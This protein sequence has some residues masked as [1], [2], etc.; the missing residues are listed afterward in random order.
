MYTAKQ[1]ILAILLLN[2][3][4]LS[5][6]SPENSSSDGTESPSDYSLEATQDS[7][8]KVTIRVLEKEAILVSF[9]LPGGEQIADTLDEI[10]LCKESAGRD[11]SSLQSRMN[12]LLSWSPNNKF[13]AVTAGHTDGFWIFDINQIQS[14]A[15]NQI[16]K[17]VIAVEMRRNDPEWGETKTGLFHFPIG[18]HGNDQFVFGAG[19][20]GLRSVYLFDLQAHQLKGNK[21]FLTDDSSR[22]DFISV[23]VEGYESRSG[24]V[25][26]EEIESQ[27][28]KLSQASGTELN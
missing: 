6:C 23:P 12:Q 5:A 18:W 22:V 20:S 7:E 24:Y 8:R 4:Y 25:S 26:L 14:S 3:F 19:L 15:E 17:T 9:T 27:V 28:T 11:C 13:L 1:L 21:Q 10:D 2:C 16:E